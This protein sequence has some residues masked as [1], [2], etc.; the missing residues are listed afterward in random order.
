MTRGY[1]PIV[2]RYG[3]PVSRGSRRGSLRT[4][5]PFLAVGPS[6]NPRSRDAV[7]RGLGEMFNH[8]TRRSTTPFTRCN[9]VSI[10]TRDVIQY[11][12][13][14]HSFVIFT[15]SLVTFH[16]IGLVGPGWEKITGCSVINASLG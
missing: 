16:I 3:I 2:T 9:R 4:S 15:V 6:P 11:D 12:C 5:G 1:L 14:F 10:T 13:C 7:L 8:S